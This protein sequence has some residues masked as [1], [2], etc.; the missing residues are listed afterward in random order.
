[1][2]NIKTANVDSIEVSQESKTGLSNGNGPSK[3]MDTLTVPGSKGSNGNVSVSHSRQGSNVSL[4]SDN[5]SLNSMNGEIGD[6]QQGVIVAMHRKMVNSLLLSLSLFIYIFCFL[7]LSGASR[8]VLLVS[9]EISS[10]PV[11]NTTD[12]RMH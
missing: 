9:R 12:C 10:S 4:V 6:C 8:S 1:M 5:G 2:T 3:A 7:S 11:W